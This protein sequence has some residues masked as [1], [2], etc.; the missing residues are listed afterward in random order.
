[1]RACVRDWR[2]MMSWMLAVL[3]AIGGISACGKNG[4]SAE[5]G[6]PA[7]LWVSAVDIGAGDMKGKVRIVAG[8]S[9]QSVTTMRI[10]GIVVEPTENGTYWWP[11]P[12]SMTS[13][14]TYELHLD[15]EL[16]PNP[17]AKFERGTGTAK[18]TLAAERPTVAVRGIFEKGS[19]SVHCFCEHDH[20]AT[21]LDPTLRVRFEITT[22]A[23]NVIDWQG[24]KTTST[25]AAVR[26][27]LNLG[28]V[29]RDVPVADVLDADR[30][31][32]PLPLTVTGRNGE[33]A[34]RVALDLATVGVAVFSYLERGPVKLGDSSPS[35][36]VTR[37]V[38]VF[39]VVNKPKL[40]GTAST[41]HDVDVVA[42]I[43]YERVVLLSC[44]TYTNASGNTGTYEFQV[45]DLRVDAYDR[46]TGT[47]LGKR[48]FRAPASECPTVILPGETG[49]SSAADPAPAFAFAAGFQKR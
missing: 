48:V 18:I 31:P 10:E 43:A 47:R 35:A 28:E 45:S 13:P 27:T 4:N 22:A 14:G 23:G 41:I 8:A 17:E 37:S 15:A 7:T 42:L 25:G 24:V 20:E 39:P 1:M 16:I 33:T 9:G 38:L 34:D 19:P 44:G 32:L 3:V 49:S 11:R 29:F 30:H 12:A 36:R 6:T 46:R 40:F 2:H 5:Q 21:T 26:V